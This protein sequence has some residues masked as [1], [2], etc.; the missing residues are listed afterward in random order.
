MKLL[1]AALGK[2]PEALNAIDMMSSC[3]E[4]I[5]TMFDTIMLGIT[6]IY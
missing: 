3:Y 2:A 4:L 6:H 5:A 1:Q